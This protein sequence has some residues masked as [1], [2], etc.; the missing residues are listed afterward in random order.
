MSV[1]N[2][3]FVSLL[4]SFKGISLFDPE[5]WARYKN[6][7]EGRIEMS[8]LGFFSVFDLVS[9]MSGE[10]ALALVFTALI[11]ISHIY[12]LIQARL[13]RFKE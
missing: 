7:D 11:V 10:R 4:R 9:I 12:I 5:I 3:D 13:G 2:G 6:T 8:L 1:D